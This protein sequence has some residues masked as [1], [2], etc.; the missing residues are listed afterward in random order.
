MDIG[1]NIVYKKNKKKNVISIIK[2]SQYPS[3]C[4]IVL[5]VLI[6]LLTN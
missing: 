6:I 4:D 5:F 1:M 3:P 2:T